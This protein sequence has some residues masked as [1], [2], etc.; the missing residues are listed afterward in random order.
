MAIMT[1]IINFL[2][3][4]LGASSGRALLGRGNGEH[5]NLGEFHRFPNEPVA[6]QGH[7]HWDEAYGHFKNLKR[8]KGGLNH[9]K[10]V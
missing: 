3:I 6:I 9:E 2:A 10:T 7:Q 1:E 8:W 4:D 5:L